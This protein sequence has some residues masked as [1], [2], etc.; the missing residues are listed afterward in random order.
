MTIDNKGKFQFWEITRKLLV[1]ISALYIAALLFWKDMPLSLIYLGGI[2]VFFSILLIGYT[3]AIG[4]TFFSF[5]RDRGTCTFKYS[6]SYIFGRS[7]KRIIISEDELAEASL[8]VSHYGL[9]KELLLKQRTRMGLS[10]YSAI[11]L[12]FLSSDKSTELLSVLS[13]IAARCNG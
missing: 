8:E 1:T 2:V 5:E 12:S 10:G 4:L 3:L 7:N 6:T 9:K 11:N 13:K